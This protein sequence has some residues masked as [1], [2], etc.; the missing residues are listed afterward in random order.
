VC[1]QICGES[2]INSNILNITKDYIG[3][4]CRQLWW[5]NSNQVPNHKWSKLESW[6]RPFLLTLRVP[7]RWSNRCSNRWPNRAIIL[8]W[9]PLMNYSNLLSEPGL[10]LHLRPHCISIYQCYQPICCVCSINGPNVFQHF[11]L[12]SVIFH[13]E[14]MLF[15]R[16]GQRRVRAA[17]RLLLF[18]AQCQL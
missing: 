16:D 5:A 15:G 2:N 17:S 6:L 8:L 1:W 3:R 9:T 14:S 4:G 18:I 11:R 12:W 7:N 10:S 13:E